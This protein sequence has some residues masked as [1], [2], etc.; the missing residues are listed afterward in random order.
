MN[1]FRLIWRYLLAVALIV[2]L[3]ILPQT[4]VILMMLGA[5]V[6]PAALVNLMLL[7]LGFR[8]V[9]GGIE[10]G[11]IA[12]PL[13]VYIG[14]AAVSGLGYMQAR[15]LTAA[16]DAANDGVRRLSATDRTFVVTSHDARL[17]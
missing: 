11:W 14:W 12:L 3:Q 4:G 9:T 7:H 8:A 17:V 2:I 6:W 16:M 13:A 5:M 10:R 1:G 15:N